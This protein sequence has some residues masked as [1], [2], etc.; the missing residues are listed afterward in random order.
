[1]L[2]ETHLLDF[3]IVSGLFRCKCQEDWA[4]TGVVDEQ[5]IIGSN[6][7]EVITC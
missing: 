7:M 6:D 4:Y 5:D 1:M 3:D 2:E